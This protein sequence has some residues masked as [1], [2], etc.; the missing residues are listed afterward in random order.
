MTPPQASHHSQPA[1]QDDGAIR[2]IA[3]PTKPLTTPK[4]KTPVTRMKTP[5]ATK[6]TKPYAVSQTAPKFTI[7]AAK[8]GSDQVMKQGPVQ[9]AR[10]RLEEQLRKEKREQ[11]VEELRKP[12]LTTPTSKRERKEEGAWQPVHGQ[13]E[14][15]VATPATPR[16]M[17]QTAMG[18]Y[19]VHQS[20]EMRKKSL[21]AGADS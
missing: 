11:R 8:P 9:E 10:A 5:A 15:V 4:M 21:Q 19:L 20:I 1:S 3:A 13:E 7:G 6:K 17:R 2:K 12:V 14:V 16:S 18:P